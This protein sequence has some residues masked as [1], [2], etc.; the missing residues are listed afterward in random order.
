M[1]RQSP[2]ITQLEFWP[3]DIPIMDPFV[4]A[5]GRVLWRRMSLSAS[6]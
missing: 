2:T 4:V 1:D 6:H 5:T 3:V